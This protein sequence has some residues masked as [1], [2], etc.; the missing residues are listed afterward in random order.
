M[1]PPTMTLT[2]RTTAAVSPVLVLT[3]LLLSDAEGVAAAGAD[4]EA[5]FILPAVP[6][7]IAPLLYSV[8]VQLLAYYAALRR[9]TD[10]D[11]P[12]NLAKSV[13]VE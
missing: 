5:A 13:T 9:G 12:R 4:I 10:I 11:R 2:L 6:D 1:T 8:P 3:F 7:F